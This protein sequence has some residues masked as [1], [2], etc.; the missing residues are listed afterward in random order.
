MK[1][2]IWIVGLFALAVLVGLASTVNT[3][4]AILFLPPYRME[5]SFNALIIGILLLIVVVHFVLR[6]IGIAARMPEEVRRFQRQKKLKAARHAL[7][8]AG[9]AFFE[10]R[11]QRAER[12][13]IRAI[14]NEESEDNRALAL[15]IAAR[16]AGSMRDYDKRNQ[17]LAKLDALP[18]R[19]QLAH[20]VLEA[21]LKLDAKDAPGAL[22]AVERARTISP[23]LTSALKIELRIRLLQK[24]PEAVLALTEKLLK[25]DAIDAEQARRYRLTAYRQQLAALTSGAEIQAWFKRIPDVERANP[26]LLADVVA[27]L[28]E[29][30][31]S[32]QA[33]TLIAQALGDEELATPELAQKL[34]RLAASL[35][36][37][38][39][40][41]LMHEAEGWLTSRPNDHLLLLALGRLALAQQLWGKAQSYLEASLSLTPTLTA[42]AE[43]AR[44][45]EATGKEGEAHRH[46]TQCLRM[47]LEMGY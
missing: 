30:E 23:N 10:G 18:S 20:H 45:F 6:L 3:G 43:L 26:D 25:S 38:K 33:A 15:L 19:L 21:E 46:E 13:A 27:R 16:A 36:P 44:L 37:D 9:I 41:A 31:D 34:G 29:L 12:E 2:V 40:L 17:Y 47:A 39:R 4:Y 22:A 5:V 28:T 24:Q 32:D 14:D 7:R 1:F 35:S 42:H 8:E 11:F